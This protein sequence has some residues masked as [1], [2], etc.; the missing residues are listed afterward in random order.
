MA[1]SCWSSQSPRAPAPRRPARGLMHPSASTQARDGAGAARAARVVCGT[2]NGGKGARPGV[3]A[4]PDHPNLT[5]RDGHPSVAGTRS[6]PSDARAAPDRC[7]GGALNRHLVFRAQR[8]S[9]G[10]NAAARLTPRRAPPILPA[11]NRISGDERDEYPSFPRQRE[12]AAGGSRCEDDGEWTR[13][14]PD[15]TAAQ[16]A[17]VGSGAGRQR[18]HGSTDRPAAG[19][20]ARER[21]RGPG[22]RRRVAPRKARPFVPVGRKVVLIPGGPRR[23]R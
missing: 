5:S 15:R 16:A 20:S 1:S 3:R 17:P 10:R 11:Y 22:C 4:R 13:E 2:P 7:P 8:P 23:C 21:P 12:P 6:R 19:P 9:A 18:Y 14:P